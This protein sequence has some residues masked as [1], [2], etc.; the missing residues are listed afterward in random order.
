MSQR[1][2]RAPSRD[3]PKEQV[4][5]REKWQLVHANIKLDQALHVFLTQ[6]LDICGVTIARVAFELVHKVLNPKGYVRLDHKSELE[7]VGT[8]IR[9]RDSAWVQQ[10][11]NIN[12]RWDFTDVWWTR[13][14]QWSVDYSYKLLILDVVD[15]FCEVSKKINCHNR[16]ENAKYKY[17]ANDDDPD[18]LFSLQVL[19][20]LQHN[21]N[22]ITELPFN[23]TQEPVIRWETKYCD[24]S[25]EQADQLYDKQDWQEL[26]YSQ[27]SL[28]LEIGNV[29]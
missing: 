15:K 16:K 14:P 7:N 24:L 8:L 28:E 18:K 25:P 4:M 27:K 20:E 9:N 10:G 12:T 23:N 5:V 17:D 22:Q 3:I 26:Q 6:P 19:D 13:M 2:S 1:K 11:K 21:I 29:H